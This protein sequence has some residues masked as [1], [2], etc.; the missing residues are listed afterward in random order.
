MAKI[1]DMNDAWAPTEQLT[2]TLRIGYGNE[3]V[4]LEK[5]LPDG[6]SGVYNIPHIPPEHM[7]SFLAWRASLG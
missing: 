6:T 7:E 5:T 4:Y 3:W 1:E 2:P